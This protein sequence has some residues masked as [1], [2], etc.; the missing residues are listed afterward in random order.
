[1]KILVLAILMFF[2]SAIAIHTVQAGKRK[3][4]CRRPTPTPITTEVPTPMPTPLIAEP[5]PPEIPF[6]QEFSV[7]WWFPTEND[8]IDTKNTFL[9]EMSMAVNGD[10]LGSEAFE[11]KPVIE[12]D[13]DTLVLG[14]E[15]ILIPVLYSTEGDGTKA[16]HIRLV[17][18]EEL[19]HERE[20]RLVV[21]SDEHLIAANFGG[22][23]LLSD[24]LIFF[25][26]E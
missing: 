7:L 9:L 1:M 23:K 21:K 4:P 14:N 22:D 15:I 26:T 13:Y 20:Y 8:V 24:L 2:I 25:K 3:R 12:K 19:E 16:R 11:L 17:P 18:T 10:R 5:P 6:R